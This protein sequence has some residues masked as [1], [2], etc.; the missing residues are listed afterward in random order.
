M[1][2]SLSLVLFMCL[3]AASQAFSDDNLYTNLQEVSVTVNTGD[4]D[5]SE[6]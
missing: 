2:K 6:L 3:Y 4:S 5:L 1:L